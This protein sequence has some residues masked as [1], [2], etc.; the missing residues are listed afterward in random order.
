M[1]DRFPS[2][3]V[4]NWSNLLWS[5]GSND[6]AST[7][8]DSKNTVKL[9]RLPMV[10]QS[11][12]HS[13]FSREEV[14]QQ[15]L[16]KLET[17]LI[18]SDQHKPTSRLG[19]YF[20]RLWS[21]AFQYHPDYQLLHQNLPLRIEGRTLGE[22]DFVVQHLPTNRC[23]HW[24]I[25]VKFYLALPRRYWVG[26]G[27][28]DRLDIK[29]KRMAEHQLPLIQQQAVQPLLNA[30]GLHIEQQWTLMPGRLFSPLP[31]H[32]NPFFNKKLTHLQ[33]KNWWADL[34][35][36]K[37]LFQ[38][39]DT[40]GL[41]WFH[42][43]KRAWLAPIESDEARGNSFKQLTVGLENSTVNKPLCFALVGEKGEISRG[44]IVPSN[45]LQRALEALPS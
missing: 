11:Q 1:S 32:S 39:S 28:K 9:P 7:A 27:L 4:N 13:Y 19:V 3:I 17:H 20:E 24:E 8:S 34:E 15:L 43:P 25:A 6:I 35:T 29:I 44:F 16:N 30:L 45:W 36:F 37:G 42:L 23:E 18:D 41:R 33:D 26:P 14:K 5:L 10:R 12:L 31:I 2:P 21:F 40:A 38:G 22:L